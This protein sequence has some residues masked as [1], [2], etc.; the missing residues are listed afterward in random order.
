VFGMLA[1]KDAGAAAAALND[2]VDAWHVAD[3]ADPRG[4]SA[5]AL[6]ASLGPAVRGPVH[7]HESAVLAYDEARRQSRPEDRILVF[8]SFHIAGNI[9]AHLDGQC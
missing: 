4:R 2:V 7:C 5:A 9:L 6:A 8:G 3:I 1:D